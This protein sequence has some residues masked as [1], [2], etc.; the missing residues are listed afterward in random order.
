[1]W[2]LLLL[3]PPVVSGQHNLPVVEQDCGEGCDQA[4]Q[5]LNQGL[6][7]QASGELT[8][9]KQTAN[10]AK[11]KVKD[12]FDSEL[13]KKSS[14]LSTA[15]AG[16]RQDHQANLA[17]F[18]AAVPQVDQAL[19][20]AQSIFG[21][22]QTKF[23]SQDQTLGSNMKSDVETFKKN[24]D[25]TES[26]FN[27]DAASDRSVN[28]KLMGQKAKEVQST[29]NRQEGDVNK[30]AQAV[31]KQVHKHE[32]DFVKQ[33]DKTDG[34]L[35]DGVDK[36][37]DTL[38][39][40]EYN[41]E[42]LEE[43]MGEMETEVEGLQE[44]SDPGAI[45]YEN[46]LEEI[47]TMREDFLTEVEDEVGRFEED[48]A[49]KLKNT[50][51]TMERSVEKTAKAAGSFAVNAVRAVDDFAQKGKNAI[52]SY[53]ATTQ[54]NGESSIQLMQKQLPKMGPIEKNVEQ[55]QKNVER[56]TAEAENSAEQYATEEE[57]AISALRDRYLSQLSKDTESNKA[58][59][60][61]KQ[62]ILLAGGA[63]ST[64]QVDSQGM[65][66]VQQTELNFDS[67]VQ[68]ISSSIEGAQNKMDSAWTV[69][70]KVEAQIKQLG[71]GI[72]AMQGGPANAL[73]KLQDQTVSVGEAKQREATGV[74]LAS[75]SALGQMAQKQIGA[76]GQLETTAND[77]LS[78]ARQAIGET[79]VKDSSSV[80]HD[81]NA[82]ANHGSE[83]AATIQGEMVATE[84]RM[85]NIESSYEEADRNLKAL[86]GDVQTFKDDYAGKLENANF[87]IQTAGEDLASFSKERF[88]EALDEVTSSIGNTQTKMTQSI[89]GE[90]RRVLQEVDK[91]GQ[92]LEQST[93]EAANDR[94]TRLKG[95]QGIGGE[96]QGLQTTINEFG[97]EVD[98]TVERTKGAIAEATDKVLKASGQLAEQ[99]DSTKK[100]YEAE[101]SKYQDEYKQQVN[102][103]INRMEMKLEEAV[104]QISGTLQSTEKM[105]ET[106]VVAKRDAINT[107]VNGIKEKEAANLEQNIDSIARVIDSGKVSTLLSG[108]GAAL[109]TAEDASKD[110]DNIFAIL[111]EGR[112][113]I[114]TAQHDAVAKAEASFSKS[115]AG[116]AHNGQVALNKVRDEEQMAQ[117]E[118]QNSMQHVS[119][120]STASLQAMRGEV[121]GVQGDVMAQTR[122]TAAK[123]GAL[124]ENL[125][126]QSRAIQNDI[127]TQASIIAGASQDAATQARQEQEK[128]GMLQRKI[129][130]D[131]NE[132]DQS[133]MAMEQVMNGVVGKIDPSR[134]I[135]SMNGEV[136]K[137]NQQMEG[138]AK[139]ESDLADNANNIIHKLLSQVNNRLTMMGR[140]I[141][142]KNKLIQGA[143]AAIP[144]EFSVLQ[145]KFQSD[146]DAVT[147]ILMDL[148]D[149]TQDLKTHVQD[150]ENRVKQVHEANEA[151][152][153]N[154]Q[155][156]SEYDDAEALD[157]VLKQLHEWGEMDSGILSKMDATLIPRMQ[158]W[159]EG[160]QTVF[161]NLGAGLDMEKVTKSA[162]QRM[163]EEQVLRDEMMR[164]QQDLE[165]FLRSQKALENQ[166]KRDLE[167][168]VN[169][170]IAAV[171]NDVNLSNEEKKKKIQE[172]MERAAKEKQLMEQLAQR[173]GEDQRMIGLSLAERQKLMEDLLR[174]ARLAIEQQQNPMPR[175][176]LQAFRQKVENTLKEVSSN[177]QPGM[178]LMQI[179]GQ[180]VDAA[181]AQRA[182]HQVRAVERGL[183]KDAEKR[184]QREQA[185]EDLLDHLD[186]DDGNL[187][188]QGL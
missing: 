121:D 112:N 167:K 41:S 5:D 163:E 63:E 110:S 44:N 72:A 67:G 134:D 70:G 143:S 81:V 15:A 103:M 36:L 78:S 124:N 92:G 45:G 168:R 35:E 59:L 22:T 174:R 83:Q 4:I 136:N 97:P 153:G 40:A 172:I 6:L 113:G 164:A 180:V 115:R 132:V 66:K 120:T 161:E 108:A 30:F 46:A 157:R 62:K 89:Q 71:K 171:Q 52:S 159:Y 57:T 117:R 88:E 145:Q 128:V 82:L 166:K 104:T 54:K 186:P 60:G 1:M 130:R 154:M 114:A 20:N 27:K 96:L 23:E 148:H 187:R 38:E 127:D 150:K 176:E 3:L 188:R 173:M 55:L 84:E 8:A 25:A 19:S 185:W 109:R 170:D 85:K 156:M 107:Q 68:S 169:A 47:A 16:V 158:H 140:L 139:M 182:A 142:D 61:N 65:S 11:Q 111:A 13:N 138:T 56:Q 69:I 155:G 32:T 33:V 93:A 101:F 98:K 123:A 77:E 183:R 135:R 144:K 86:P 181:Q 34:K 76:I 119:A 58:Y 43:L 74:E 24:A 48:G 17:A 31:M 133:N 29:L 50:E 149:V 49:E 51:R 99:R 178:S 26:E 10:R 179:G 39:E 91:V 80:I 125:A 18:T 126:A 42:D 90:T 79:I 7:T 95:Q 165:G 146:T 137:L 14:A 116:L 129:E 53:A 100:Q 131:A 75:L 152:L 94:E 2:S 147:G 105:T 175:A 21:Q 162:K 106:S 102:A 151:Q 141:S 118:F 64:A 87:S 28:L 160:V 184:S 37:T 122:S 177:L 9:M 12:E 73:K